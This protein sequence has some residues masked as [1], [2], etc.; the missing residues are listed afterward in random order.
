MPKYDVS[1]SAFVLGI[2]LD[3]EPTNEEVLQ[4]FADMPEA[5]L[6]GGMEVDSIEKVE[7]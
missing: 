7:E 5:E 2:E 4:I 6:I 3:K 1:V